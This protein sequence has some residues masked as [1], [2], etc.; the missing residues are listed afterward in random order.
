MNVPRTHSVGAHEPANSTS[1]LVGSPLAHAVGPPVGFVEMYADVVP[2][3]MHSDVDAHVIALNESSL[4]TVVACQLGEAPDGVVDV[5]ALPL[6][7]AAMQKLALGQEIALMNPVLPVTLGVQMGV[8][9]LGFVEMYAFPCSST[10][11][12]KLLDGHEI[13]LK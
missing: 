5:K 2:P 11:A 8:A 4:L 13:A 3:I 7:S 10:R 1:P 9:A 12:Q 6:S